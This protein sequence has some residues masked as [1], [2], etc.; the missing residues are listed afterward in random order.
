MR[1]LCPTILSFLLPL[2]DDFA[3][4]AGA[5][6]TAA[7]ADGKT[8]ALLHGHWSMQFNFQLHVVPRHHHL[9]AFGQLRRAGH[10]RGA[11]VKLRAVTIEKR[12]VTA[13]L[14]LAQNVNLALELGVRGNGSRLGQHH[15][16]LHVFLGN[17]T[18]QQTRV[19]SGKSFIQ[20]L[21]EHFDAGDHG[22]AGLPETDDLRLFANLDLAPLDPARH[23]RATAGNGENV[24]DRHQERLVNGTRRQGDVLVPPIHQLINL[25]FPLRFSV[26]PAQG[27][28]ANDRHIVPR[29]VVL[30]QQFPDFH[31]HQVGQLFVFDRVALVQKHDDVGN[32]YL[33][34][35]QN[36]LLGLRHWTVGGGNYKNRSVHLRRAGDH[37]LDVVGVTR[38]IDVRVVTVGRL[39]LYVRGRDGDAAL[40]LLRRVVDRIKRAKLD[41]RIML[42]QYLCD[43]CRQGR[44]AVINVSN[45]PNVHVRFGPVK[46]FLRHL[47]PLYLAINKLFTRYASR[48][49]P[50]M[51]R[52]HTVSPP[53]R[54]SSTS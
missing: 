47:V 4:G 34:G 5:Y 11:E 21:F 28:A 33:T 23:Y 17:T 19:V 31:F 53:N 10:V 7:L 32:A 26:Q 3:D 36:V 24:F 8:Q 54:L 52:S 27:G 44:L 42:R 12:G 43:C 18:Q 49:K 48:G 1:I 35:E 39:V 20:L 46:L 38:A 9:G 16:A 50:P 14:F 15:A 51:R 37:V 25:G 22:L 2:L 45:R 29:E 6:R 40:P 41:L 13:A 30:R